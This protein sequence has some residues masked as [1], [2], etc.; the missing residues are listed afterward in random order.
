[1]ITYIPTSAKRTSA[2]EFDD[3]D[4]PQGVKINPLGEA[5]FDTAT[6]ASDRICSEYTVSTLTVDLGTGDLGTTT[7]DVFGTGDYTIQEGLAVVAGDVIEIEGFVHLRNTYSGP[8]DVK[9][10]VANQIGHG[11]KVGADT[12]SNYA[13]MGSAMRCI[14]IGARFAPTT[15][16]QNLYL[17]IA[18]NTNSGNSLILTGPVFLRI[19]Q[20]RST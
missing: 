12:V 7:T 11:G 18:T 15:G 8:N 14:P 17:Q 20:Y 2:L 4:A 19:K 3:G 1:M 16:S 5:A 6:F 9:V 10:R 13:D